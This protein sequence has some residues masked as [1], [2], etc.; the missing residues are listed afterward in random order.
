MTSMTFEQRLAAGPPTL[1]TVA[2]RAAVGDLVYSM[3][4]GHVHEVTFVYPVILGAEPRGVDAVSLAHRE[5]V[6]LAHRDAVVLTKVEA[7]QAREHYAATAEA[8]DR[9]S[10]EAERTYCQNRDQS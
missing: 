3:R 1:R 8:Y 4:D 6:R 2:R 7:E 10:M 9:A 5:P